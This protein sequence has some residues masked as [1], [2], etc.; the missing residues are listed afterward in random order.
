M[1]GGAEGL[2]DAFE[3]LHEFVRREDGCVFEPAE[4][5]GLDGVSVEFN[6]EQGLF[7][8]AELI[9]HDFR[10]DRADG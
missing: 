9:P 6:E 1:S 4:D 7:H 2:H 10:E 3:F 5:S 8:G